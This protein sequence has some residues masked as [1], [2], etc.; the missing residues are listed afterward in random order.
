MCSNKL[1]VMFAPPNPAF[2]TDPSPAGFE[3][4]GARRWRRR[5]G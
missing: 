4:L 1:H 2:N 3:L 5:A